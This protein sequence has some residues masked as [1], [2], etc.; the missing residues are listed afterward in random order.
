[1]AIDRSFIVKGHGTVVTGSVTSGSLAVG[2]EV[3]WLP[4]GERVRVRSLQNHSRSVQT[5]QRGMRAAINLAGIHHENVARG[6]ELA[7]PGYLRPTRTLT[8]RAHCLAAAGRP[9]KH[10]GS[11]R[12]HIGTAE[13]MG[14][15]AVLDGERIEPGGWGQ[16]QVFLRE[17]VMAVWGQPFVLR[18]PSAAQTLGGGQVL[19]PVTRKLRR[20]QPDVLERLDL[21]WTGNAEQRA[22]GAAWFAGFAG[23]T[24]ADLIRGAGLSPLEAAACS[25]SLRSQG[26]LV[27]IGHNPGLIHAEVLADLQERIRK[28][29]SRLHAAF[30]LQSGHDRQ[31]LRA[32]LAYVGNDDVVD[33]A[34]DRLRQQ[35]QIVAEGSLIR[36]TDFKP[37]TR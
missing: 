28:S 5:V 6:Q 3:E 25:A 11:V 27:G 26:G 37:R 20:Q 17:P 24:G 18:A 8:V 10:R 31:K 16:A 13:V 1:M 33:C 22:L 9:L 34:I 4:R 14:T 21:L 12:F 29:L 32:E 2:D 7:A 36:R 15:L 23:V 35:G 19:Q 30:P